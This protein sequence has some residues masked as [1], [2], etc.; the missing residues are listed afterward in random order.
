MILRCRNY[1]HADTEYFL[2]LQRLKSKSQVVSNISLRMVRNNSGE[3]FHLHAGGHFSLAKTLRFQLISSASYRL[4]TV[5]S[6]EY[7]L[8]GE[9]MELIRSPGDSLT[10]GMGVL[11]SSNFLRSPNNQTN[12]RKTTKNQ[13]SSF[14][15]KFIT[16]KMAWIM[17]Y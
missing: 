13:P 10:F 6:F 11:M 12:F 17:T 4:E 5:S 8:L 3:L 2:Q 14:E 15:N 1:C 9:P 7:H 16:K